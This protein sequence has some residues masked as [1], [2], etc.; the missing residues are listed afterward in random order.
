MSDLVIALAL[1]AALAN[2]PASPD[3]PENPCDLI[4]S[5]DLAVVGQ[6]V[7]QPGRRV[8]G[9]MEVGPGT[10]CVFQ[11]GPEFGEIMVGVA[12]RAQRRGAK[13]LEARDTYFRSYPGSGRLVAG[14]G[15]DA[16][17]GGGTSLHVLIRDDE[18]FTLTTQ[19][20]QPESGELL[21]KIAKFV[22][23]KK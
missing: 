11:T 8:P 2:G 21:A 16:W 20:Y 1:L 9:K 12:P 19:N 7:V 6:L 14:V 5:A 18:Y 13:Y 17:L 23:A 3:L 22:L 4:E 15:Q 10:I